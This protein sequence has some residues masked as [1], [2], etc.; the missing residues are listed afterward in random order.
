MSTSTDVANYQKY[1]PAEHRG[2][3]PRVHVVLRRNPAKTFD[4]F[5]AAIAKGADQ[6]REFFPDATLIQPIHELSVGVGGG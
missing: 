2:L 3:I 1:L 6:L 4:G 5:R